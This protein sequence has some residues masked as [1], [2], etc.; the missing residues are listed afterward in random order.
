V[1][2]L[3]YPAP[4]KFIT[5]INIIIFIIFSPVGTPLD[6]AWFQAFSSKP[7]RSLA[8]ISISGRALY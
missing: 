7:A 6:A 8:P 2:N 4:E 3:P 1:G 5:F